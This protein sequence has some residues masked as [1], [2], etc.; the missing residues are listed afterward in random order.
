MMAYNFHRVFILLLFVFFQLA[1]RA[2]AA[3]LP[4]A[5]KTLDNGLTVLVTEMPTS[6]MVSV[7]G[8]VRAGSAT[9]GDY[10]GAGTSHFLEHM[11]FK[12]TANRGV[13]EV[14]AD[15]QAVG[16]TINATTSM[17]QTIFIITVPA[18]EVATAVD[19]L[20][21]QLFH[22]TLDDAEFAKEREVIF[23][24]MRMNND[25]PERRISR[26]TFENVYRV[27]PYRLPVIGHRELFEKVTKDELMA[28][29][30]ANYIPDNIV[31]SVAGNVRAKQAFALIEEKFASMP[32]G[33]PVVRNLPEEPEQL[34]PRLLE[35]TYP[36]EITRLTLAYPSVSMLSRD[37]FALD[38]LSMVL[39]QGRASRL[40]QKLY[41]QDQ[42]VKSI[43]SWNYTPFDKGVFVVEAELDAANV[44]AAMAAIKSEILKIQKTG[45]TNNELEK[46]KRQVL[47]GHVKS[48][49][50][51]DAVAYQTAVDQA[52]T[53]D[54][55]FSERYVKQ[56]AAVTADDVKRVADQYLT[57][58][59]LNVTILWPEKDAGQA[60]AAAASGVKAEIQKVTLPNG[61][62]VLLRND[63]TFPLVSVRLVL[64]GGTRLE[65]DDN[66]GL[67]ELFSETWVRASKSYDVNELDELVES[68]GMSFSGYAG[69]NSIGINMGFLSADWQKG[70]DVLYDIVRNPA[71]PEEEIE[72]VR[73]DML[74]VLKR[75]ND[76]IFHVAARLMRESLF[77]GHPFRLN[78][79]GREESIA[80]LS[81][82]DV[83][84]YYHKVVV[85]ANM[86]LAVYGDIST[87]ELLKYIEKTFGSAVGAAPDLPLIE[88]VPIAQRVDLAGTMPKE[89]AMVLFGFQAD[90]IYSARRYALE[91]LVEV[92]GSSF[93]GRLFQNIRETQGKAYTLGGSYLPGLDAGM[94]YFYA[95]TDPGAVEEV[96]ALVE[97]E[98][99]RL[100]TGG[101]T[102]EELKEFQTYLKGSFTGGLQTNADLAFTTALDDLYGLGYQSYKGYY[103]GIDSVNAEQV[104]DLAGQYLDLERAVVVVIKPSA[105]ESGE[106]NLQ[107][108]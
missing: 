22:M 4:I 46:A 30:K 62:R 8:L 10:L 71:F 36:T 85:P 59:R 58:S 92:L 19:V 63:P 24:E 52:F 53:G 93:N 98:I 78:V 95:L 57:E 90:T 47:I 2:A 99:T 23:N 31:V 25:N 20:A 84:D 32:R 1:G 100:K 40:F 105:V 76:S 68:Y 43:S 28:Y 35:E 5:Q 72:K 26:M 27:H 69:R 106:N 41:K 12:T 50:T 102:P 14:A 18:A 51:T 44:Q 107:P 61:M 81:R 17:D 88:P 79:E 9:E 67:S 64:Q 7:Y 86:V 97:A 39:G 3:S 45:I 48:Q 21:D 34:T 13:G 49:Q 94:V 66:N 73:K 33:R 91:A 37:L 65:N 11:T 38:V 103:A 42:T 83:L 56:V 70:M 60:Q 87:S 101:I 75:Q 104:R 108:Q 96:K 80:R 15:I 82:Q 74:V 6:D 89:Q 16:G 29:Y 55:H 54:A 77:A